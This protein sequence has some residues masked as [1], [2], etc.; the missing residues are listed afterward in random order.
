MKIKRSPFLEL[1]L[2]EKMRM[3][4]IRSEPLFAFSVNI[5]IVT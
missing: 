1:K 4:N 3:S 5:L 2:A